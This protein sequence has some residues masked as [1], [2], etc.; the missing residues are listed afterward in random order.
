MAGMADEADGRG[1]SFLYMPTWHWRNAQPAGAA[2]SS[3][4]P[5]GRALVYRPGADSERVWRAVVS[6]P[7]PEV[8]YNRIAAGPADVSRDAALRQGLD[9]AGA[10][11]FNFG[12]ITKTALAEAVA[13]SPGF[14]VQVPRT[15]LL[16]SEALLWSLLGSGK[17][18]YLKP[19]EG[20]HGQGAVV[21][22]P[23]GQSAYDVVYQ[24]KAP[25]TIWRE[26][27]ADETVRRLGPILRSRPHIAQAVA[28]VSTAD[29][30]R[31]TSVR[32]HVCRDGEGLWQV[33]A[34]WAAI[35]GPTTASSHRRYGGR[36]VTAGEALARMDLPGA[37]IPVDALYAAGLAAARALAGEGR[38]AGLLP[39]LVGEL[40]L[41]LGVDGAGRIW[42]FEANSKPG[43]AHG[44]DD[45]VAAGVRR[46][47]SM[48][49][50]YMEH[51]AVVGRSNIDAKGMN[52]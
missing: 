39:G 35:G 15:W 10:V 3:P 31:V 8:V 24:P 16:A 48:L 5:G 13:R 43:F 18:F 28:P 36:W 52:D 44:P 33:A 4:A 37:R 27:K 50:D 2:R 12:S 46:V 11:V 22:R 38:R 30:G 14:P 41:D 7:W 47:G 32:V 21:V 1:H 40:G 26:L 20:S 19:S 34:S 51:L 29:G 17:P 42:L 23:V 25:P 45:D 49:M 6:A 9:R